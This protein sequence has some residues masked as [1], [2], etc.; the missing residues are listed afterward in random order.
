M[1]FTTCCDWLIRRSYSPSYESCFFSSS[2]RIQSSQTIE[3]KPANLQPTEQSNIISP[4]SLISSLSSP[5][6]FTT[7]YYQ[8]MPSTS[9]WYCCKCNLGPWN[10]MLDDYCPSCSAVRCCDCLMESV[11]MHTAFQTLSHRQQSPMSIGNPHA[12]N[13]LA[14]CETLRN[15]SDS[16]ERASISSMTPIARPLLREPHA[17]DTYN[18]F[19]YGGLL[20][21]MPSNYYYCCQCNDGPKMYENQPMCVSCC[22]TICHDCRPAWRD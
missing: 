6:T 9:V 8:A 13:K 2:F 1:L 20:R 15:R 16:L 11:D 14:S 22:H 12:C 19:N 4:L 21:Q 17:M 18:I 3:F 7:T 10:V 5:S